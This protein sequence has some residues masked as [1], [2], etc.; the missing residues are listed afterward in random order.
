MVHSGSYKE[1]LDNTESLTGDYLSGR[2]K[3]E[4][5]KKRRKYDKKRELKVVGAREN[6]L[7]NVDA[8]PSRWACSPRLP[9]S[10]AP[11][12]PPWSTRSSTRSWPTSSTAPSR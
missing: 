5:P 6:N 9:A 12:S 4:I 7:L 2:K 1:L 8:Q 11:A 10:A 3:I